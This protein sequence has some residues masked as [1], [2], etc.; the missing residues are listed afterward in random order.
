MTT[1]AVLVDKLIRGGG[2]SLLLDIISRLNDEI[3]FKIWCLGRIDEDVKADFCEHGVSPKRVRATPYS[4]RE[5]YAQKPLLPVIQL[6]R[7]QNIDILHGYSLYCNFISRISTSV[8]YDVKNISQH[9]G[10][11]DGLTL[12]KVANILTNRLSDC[13]ICVSKAVSESV[14]PLSNPLGKLVTGEDIR[15]IHNPIDFHFLQESNQQSSKVLQQYGL[16]NHDQLLVSVGR[17][18]ESK[19]HPSTIQAMAD[20]DD[21]TP[22][23]VIIGGGKLRQDFERQIQNIG[24]EN[25]VTLLGQVSRR[26]CTAIVSEATIFISSSIREGF[27]IALAEA[28]ALGKPIIASDIPAYREVG[29]EHSIEYF[30]PQN[31]EDLANKI[32]NLLDNPHKMEDKANNAREFANRYRIEEITK[33]YREVYLTLTQ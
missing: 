2:E 18:T 17:L 31:P 11:K 24:V 13:T 4:R 33:E 32:K 27:G 23:L 16:A 28:M 7:Q 1:V 10:V 12:S 19:D 9:H 20:L 15:V 21:P 6:L 30:G 29:N 14:Y 5:K 26:D 3:K 22:H 25:Q 8:V